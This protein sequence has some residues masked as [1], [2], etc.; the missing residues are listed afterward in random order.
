MYS[1]QAMIHTSGALDA[2][3]LAPAQAAGTQIGAFHPLVAF[4]DTERAVAALHG[5]TVAIEGDDQLLRSCW[6]RWPRSSVPGRS[7]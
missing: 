2:S 3:V 7:A 1:G 5:A 4:A 6:R